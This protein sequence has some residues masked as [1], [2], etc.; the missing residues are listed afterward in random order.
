MPT[1]THLAKHPGGG[2]GSDIAVQIEL[3]G[4]NGLP[5]AGHVLGSDYTV[6]GLHEPGVDSDGEWSEVLEAN[7]TISPA[8]TRWKVTESVDGRPYVYYANVLESPATQRLEDVLD[9]PPG[10]LAS[11]ALYQHLV[12]E[13][14]HPGL[15]GLPPGGTLGQVLAK[16]SGADGDAGW[17]DPTNPI[18]EGYIADLDPGASYVVD[19]FG[20]RT[21]HRVQLNE[22]L[23]VTLPDL[24]DPEFDTDENSYSFTLLTQQDIVGG[25]ALTIDGDVVWDED[26]EPEWTIAAQGADVTAFFSHG[27]QWIGKRS[28]VLPG[29]TPPPFD[30][31]VDISWFAYFYADQLGEAN[32][33]TISLWADGSGNN[34]HVSQATTAN[35]PTMVTA[36]AVLNNQKAVDFDT[37]DALASAAFTSDAQPHT[38]VVVGQS[39]RVG[40]NG[41]FFDGISSTN[42]HAVLKNAANN[43]DIRSNNAIDMGVP[44]GNIAHLIIVEFNAG[45]SKSIVD[46]VVVNAPST[47][48]NV[49]LTGIT[50]G[51]RYD[52]TNSLDGKIAFAG[53]F[54]GLLSDAQKANLLAWARGKYATP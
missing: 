42:R 12:D 21:F 28:L 19:L 39:D 51:A 10:A 25:H 7:A 2:A 13:D 54:D 23:T 22:S 9:D 11:P 17:A 33:A 14:P 18:A 24:T 3:A 40:V 27:A 50:V 4:E 35:R 6:V 48:G 8:G 30:P 31:T 46:G 41:T 5:I 53:L 20:G 43:L 34:R 37:T 38:V 44:L 36:A 26:T 16:E 49:A 45:S 15:L 1:L 29:F 32:G 47:P 52:G